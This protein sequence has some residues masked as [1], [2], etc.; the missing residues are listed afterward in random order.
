MVHVSESQI[1]QKDRASF[2]HSWMQELIVLWFLSASIY[3]VLCW[4]H[5]PYMVAKEVAGSFR[6]V[7]PQISMLAARTLLLPMN[8]ELNS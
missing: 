6:C 8:L 3:F 5:S 2:R 1:L 4:L 7:F